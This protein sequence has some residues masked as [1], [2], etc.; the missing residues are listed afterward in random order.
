MSKGKNADRQ[1]RPLPKIPG[2]PAKLGKPLL[3]KGWWIDPYCRRVAPVLISKE[4]HA[5]H[6]AL[7][8]DCVGMVRLDAY[9]RSHNY[10]DVWVDD[11]G[12]LYTPQRPRFKLQGRA[13]CG[14]G[15]VFGGSQ[16]GDTL[17]IDLD[18]D[19]LADLGLT[20]E[21]WEH[22]VEAEH[23]FEQLSFIVEYAPWNHLPEERR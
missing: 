3:I 9:D 11:N 15:L 7:E 13:L 5:W 4:L 8:C 20:F 6:Q 14:Y 1:P 22:Y 16:F 18:I 23:F 10:I 17:S 12:R 2:N 19:G 21:N